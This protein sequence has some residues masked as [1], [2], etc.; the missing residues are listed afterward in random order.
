MK[1]KRQ[2][3]G[4]FGETL[5]SQVANC[6]ACLASRSFK[7]LPPN[8]RVFDLRCASCELSVQVKTL[9][10]PDISK[11]PKKLI[12]AAWSPMEAEI[13]KRGFIHFYIV[14]VNEAM[15]AAVFHLAPTSQNLEMFEIRKPLGPNAKSPGWVGFMV[16]LQQKKSDIV[17][18]F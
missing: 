16:D 9:K 4:A 8:T 15:E 6:P 12:G 2:A 3:L 11:L 18:I 14:L 10:R 1:T 13:Q 17:R 5:V 7:L